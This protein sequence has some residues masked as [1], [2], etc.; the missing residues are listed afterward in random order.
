MLGPSSSVGCSFGDSSLPCA[1]MTRALFC[2]CI[3][4]T[5]QKWRGDHGTD[6]G[7]PSQVTK[8]MNIL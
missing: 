4:G 5:S 2:T 1:L 7:C 3:T 8:S 6:R